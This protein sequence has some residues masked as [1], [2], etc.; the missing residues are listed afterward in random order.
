M[1]VAYPGEGS[2]EGFWAILGIMAVAVLALA[3]YFRY[4]RWL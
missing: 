2:A 4:K 1:N 3:G